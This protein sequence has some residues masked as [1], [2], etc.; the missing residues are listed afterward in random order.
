[1]ISELI[2]RK[3]LIRGSS[4]TA[5]VRQRLQQAATDLNRAGLLQAQC[6]LMNEALCRFTTMVYQRDTDGTWA[7]I[8]ARTGRLLVCAPWGNSGWK[9]WGLRQWEAVVL[10]AVLMSRFKESTRPPLFDYSDH[11]KSWYL[12][13]NSYPT[14]DV[15]QTYLE[16]STIALGE[17]RQY[18]DA[19]HQKAIERKQN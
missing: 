14:L 16:R 5:H 11:T 2:D 19:Y 18:G 15:A 6:E 13:A 7:N 10:R 8:D 17:W 4:P 1:M 9:R 12:N 3:V